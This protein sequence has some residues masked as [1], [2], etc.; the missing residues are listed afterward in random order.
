MRQLVLAG[1]PTTRTRQVREAWSLR[2]FPWSMN[3][4]PFAYNKSDLSIPGPLGAA[5]INMAI[6]AFLNP[7]DKSEV[8]RTFLRSGKEQSWSSA[9]TPDKVFWANG[10]SIRF[11]LIG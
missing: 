1:L 2:A 4:F 8:H 11:K 3:I 10:R 6:S 9:A 5:P 7:S